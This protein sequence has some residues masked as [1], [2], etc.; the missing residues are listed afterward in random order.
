MAVGLAE[1]PLEAGGAPL[2]AVA[3]E[4]ALSGV[5]DQAAALLDALP[6]RKAPQGAIV[7]SVAPPLPPQWA[8]ALLEI[9][10]P[11]GV[12][13]FL[14]V[15]V[16]TAVFPRQQLPVDQPS[17]SLPLL[18]A[19]AELVDLVVATV[20][21]EAIPV[22]QT[23]I[24]LREAYRLLCEAMADSVPI[25]SIG[26]HPL[27]TT[28]RLSTPPFTFARQSIWGLPEVVTMSLVDSTS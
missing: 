9:L 22:P 12:Q 3:L 6:P 28:T 27:G 11:Q 25:V 26:A 21:H 18:V 14:G 4:V 10:A 7:P 17:H 23:P 8:I 13:G 5:A 20:C 19:L 1:A 24:W 15:L 2:V 16:P